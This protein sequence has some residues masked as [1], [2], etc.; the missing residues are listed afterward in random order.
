MRV[1]KNFIYNVL[2]QILIMILPLITAP[3]IA[4]VLGAEKIGIYSY[5]YSIAYYFVLF[6]QLGLNVY[7]NRSIAIV[8]D[9][10]EKLSKTFSS[11]FIVQLFI[12]IISCICYLLFI[13]FSSSEYRLIFIIQFVFVLSCVFDINWFF[14]GIE[15]FKLTVIR[16]T[17]IKIATV[18]CVLLFVKT[19][20]DLWKYTTIMAVGSFLAQL[21]LWSQIR[22]YTEFKKCTFDECKVHIKPIIILFL[23]TVATSIYRVMDK[24]MLGSCTEMKELG[25]YENSEKFI[26]ISMGVINALG[27]VMIPQVSNLI[28]NKEF[29]RVKEYIHKSMEGIFILAFPIAFGLAGI[30]PI[31]SVVFYGAEFERCGSII[32]ILSF[33]IMF[34]TW[35]NVLRTQYLVPNKR[36]KEYIISMFAGSIVNLFINILLI[37]K[38]GAIGAAIGTVSAE[39]VVA[40]THSIYVKNEL[41]LIKYLK[42]II[43]YSVIGFAMYEFIKYIRVYVAISTS[44]LIQLI[45]GS[46][47]MYVVVCLCFIFISKSQYYYIIKELIPKFRKNTEV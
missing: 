3:Y 34:S 14:F 45:C 12:S 38:Y 26:A 16:N 27:T 23:P 30:A 37:P 44:G 41:E 7:G 29:K 35:A 40:L 18:V 39:A 25:F 15:K 11:I 8:R 4:R 2:Y 33:S 19:Q 21:V 20:A 31:L 36:D 28:A 46:G 9:D 42:L 1:F 43:P 24:I 5:T 32:P 10:K 17:I 47:L 13:I 6:G 22:K